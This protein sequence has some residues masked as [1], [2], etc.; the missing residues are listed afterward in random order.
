M[1]TRWKHKVVV[2]TTTLTPTE[3]D[4]LDEEGWE[5]A[6]VAV[7]LSCGDVIGQEY[8]FKRPVEEPEEPKEVGR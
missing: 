4:K 6:G 2:K 1:R 7:R 5:L 3:L 8:I